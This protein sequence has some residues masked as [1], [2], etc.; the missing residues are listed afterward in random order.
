MTGEGESAGSKTSVRRRAILAALTLAGALAVLRRARSAILRR[1]DHEATCRSAL[2]HMEDGFFRADNTGGL[3]MA[4]PSFARLFDFET[5]EEV[6]SLD[7]VRDL[8]V[9]ADQ[10]TAF[11]QGIEAGGGSIREHDFTL[12]RRDGTPLVISA[13]GH[14]YLDARGRDCLRR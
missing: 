10:L 14:F 7:L 9:D 11:R 8:G 12:R 4:S 6:E 13:T 2:D 1:R 3:V 5:P